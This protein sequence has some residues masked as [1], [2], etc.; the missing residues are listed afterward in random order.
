VPRFTSLLL[1][2]LALASS[3]D[4]QTYVSP[5]QGVTGAT[6]GHVGGATSSFVS[7]TGYRIHLPEANSQFVVLLPQGTSW[8][9]RTHLDMTL[10][11][12][13]SHLAE[14]TFAVS[15]NSGAGWLTSRAIVGPGSRLHLSM[16]LRTAASLGMVMLPS[17]A[18]SSRVQTASFG[19]Y[20]PVPV[21][22]VFLFNSDVTSLN[23]TLESMSLSTRE[24]PTSAIVDTYGQQRNHSWSGKVGRDRDLRQAESHLPLPYATDPHLGVLDGPTYP[25]SPRFRVLKDGAR[26]Y[27][28]T[29]GG[30]RF[31]SHGINE[32]GA[33]AWTITSGREH[34]FTDLANLRSKFG[35]HWLSRN[36]AEGFYPYS[37]NL[38]RR[39]GGNWRSVAQTNFMNRMATWGFNT[40][41]AHPWDSFLTQQQVPSTVVVEVRGPHAMLPVYDGRSMHDVFDSRYPTSVRDAISLRLSQGPFTVH[42]HHLGIFVDNELPWG[43][44]KVSAPAYRWALAVG[45]LNAPASQ[46]A[47]VRLVDDLK[48]KYGSIANLNASWGTAYGNWT[49]LESGSFGYP[50]SASTGMQTDFRNFAREFARRYFTTVRGA[51]TQLNYPGLYLGCRFQDTCYTPEV[52]EGAMAGGPDVHSFNIYRGTPEGINAELKH[53][54]APIMIS[55]ASFGANDLGR[56]GMFL[57]PTLTE[58]DRAAAY[59]RYMNVVRTWPNVVGVHWYRWEDFP[60]TSNQNRDNMA[61]GL[62]SIT[63]RPYVA[64]T[65]EARNICAD[66]MN[67]LRSAY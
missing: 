42:S 3:I 66:I 34:L 13:G 45:A 15:T 60:T 8:D 33:K 61:L 59:R 67:D 1:A 18:D 31:F 6:L 17:I 19:S 43:R 11:N 29:P 20:F 64:I 16:P 22:G 28:V 26:W 38:E 40:F 36:G 32:V 39:H 23:L 12:D 56:V 24:I 9:S 58:S 54:D 47:R 53:L 37:I 5:N 2:S 65:R 27:L 14:L 46:P 44:G 50:G 21:G 51:L 25:S 30:K 4:A 57:N 52:L 48:A 41:G 55:E 62:V 63:D 49:F 35:S 10:R 7:G